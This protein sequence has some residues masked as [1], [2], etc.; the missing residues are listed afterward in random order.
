[1]TISDEPA[2]E[3]TGTSAL[4][5]ADRPS[6]TER[7]QAALEAALAKAV[8][9]RDCACRNL[10]QARH[11]LER[12]GR[13]L[14][15]AQAAS[16][17]A[18]RQIEHHERRWEQFLAILAHE[19]RNPLAP[20][21]SAV[22][23][24]HLAENDH[25]TAFAARAIIERQLKH[26]VRLID[27]LVDVSRLTRGKL[28]L[29]TERM[30]LAEIVQAAIEINRPLLE[31]KQQHVRIELAPRPLIVA[32]DA[33]RLAQAFA[34]LLNNAAK[35]SDACTEIT[36]RAVREGHQAFVTI[37]D[38]GIGIP[39]GRLGGVFDTFA[40]PEPRNVSP[41]DGLGVGLTLVKRL[42]EL[43]GGSVSAESAGPGRGSAFGVRLPMLEA[44]V[45]RSQPGPAAPQR[46][47]SSARATVLVADD[48]YD[49]AQSLALMLAIDGHE[50]RT[51]RDG[52]EALRIAEDFRPDL[53]LL[54]IGMPKLDGYQTAR[55]LRK[56]PWAAD[57][58]VV[59]L[60]G[61]G[62]EEHGERARQAGF[63]RLLVK[64]VDP[65]ALSALLAGH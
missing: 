59:A 27:D 37:T 24:M 62:Q 58:R 29:K 18:R 65:E 35:Y 51:A 23:I 16:D 32:A 39:A 40:Q 34:N 30:D 55:R 43:H 10:D 38:Q 46:G 7:R 33:T 8:E 50:V 47:S 31:S 15:Q 22:Q 5:T 41:N 19:L 21:R 4:R 56:R 48:N 60:T 54:D 13:A 3:R 11:E 63:D 64:P 45:E 36:V 28:E 57:I 26:L 6:A 17:G 44:T 49:A 12:A 52:L 61:W 42:V 2:S 53:V 9:E 25:A 14:S 20:I 1:M